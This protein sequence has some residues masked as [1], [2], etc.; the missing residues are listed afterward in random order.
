VV[1]DVHETM[2]TNLLVGRNTG[3]GGEEQRK[4][5]KE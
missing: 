2:V 1:V 3:G 4:G 5:G